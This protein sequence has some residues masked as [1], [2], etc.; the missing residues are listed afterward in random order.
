MHPRAEIDAGPQLEIVEPPTAG[1]AAVEAY[2]AICDRSGA[3]ELGIATF[4]IGGARTVAKADD[5]DSLRAL[6][7][8]DCLDAEATFTGEGRF[9]LA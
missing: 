8:R 2:T 4:R 1:G 5:P 6:S 3:A 9:R 7:E